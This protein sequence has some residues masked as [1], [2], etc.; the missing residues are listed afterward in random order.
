MAG[1]RPDKRGPEPKI[2]EGGAP[3]GVRRVAQ[4]RRA[5]SWLNGFGSLSRLA[6]LR[7]PLP[8]P[9]RLRAGGSLRV[10]A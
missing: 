3:R 9:P 6:A 8:S 1:P 7:Q 4:P 10:P 5:A 2:A